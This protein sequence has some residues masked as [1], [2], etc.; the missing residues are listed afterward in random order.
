VEPWS[1]EQKFYTSQ[2]NSRLAPTVKKCV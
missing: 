1:H 2:Q